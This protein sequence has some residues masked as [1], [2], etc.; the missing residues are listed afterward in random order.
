VKDSKVK[1]FIGT[2]HRHLSGAHQAAISPL[3]SPAVNLFVVSEK[4]DIRKMSLTHE[5]LPHFTDKRER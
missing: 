2:S 5:G 4:F 3:N 1:T